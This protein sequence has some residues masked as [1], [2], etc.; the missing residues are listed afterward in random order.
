MHGTMII[1]RCDKRN[2]LDRLFCYAVYGLFVRGLLFY[3]WPEDSAY[4]S[5]PLA[6]LVAHNRLV[7][8]LIGGE[9]CW[10]SKS[11]CGRRLGA[12][13]DSRPCGK[14]GNHIYRG[15]STRSWYFCGTDTLSLGVAYLNRFESM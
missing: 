12:D 13:R 10:L 7:A 3:L 8:H 2:M 11:F 4:D 14:I 9:V 1:L 15:N 5:F 6:S